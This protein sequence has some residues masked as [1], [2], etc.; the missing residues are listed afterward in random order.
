MWWLFTFI[1]NALRWWLTLFQLAVALV[2]VDNKR[3]QTIFHIGSNDVS[4]FN[5][6]VVDLNDLPMVDYYS[7]FIFIEMLKNL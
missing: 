7:K 5:Y 6:H 1:F 2:V 3:L 4:K